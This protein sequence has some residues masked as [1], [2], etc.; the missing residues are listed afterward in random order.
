LFCYDERVKSL[1][2]S[3][4][5][6]AAL[7]RWERVHKK[8]IDEA[9]E[10]FYRYISDPI[11]V[12]GISLYWGEGDSKPKNPLRLSNTD[13]RM[14]A[15]YVTFLRNIVGIADRKIRLGLI[16]Y[17]DL[18]DADCQE[19]WS[20]KTGLPRENFMKTQYIAGRHPTKRLLHGI[21]MVVVNSRAAKLTVLTWIDIFAK[22]YT[23]V[24][25]AG[26]V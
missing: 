13:G 26:I 24:P 7:Q 9:C 4:R 17:P 5:S 19:F 21:C 25:Y 18:I 16:L 1:A 2:V 12:S 22:S 3:N 23:M 6:R 20:T 8:T 11:F 15:I 14:I 10:K